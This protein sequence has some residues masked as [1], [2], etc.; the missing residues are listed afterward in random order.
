MSDLESCKKAC[1][2]IYP[3]CAAVNWWYT[4]SVCQFVADHEMDY[5][6]EEKS[7]VHYSIY[8]CYG[9]YAPGDSGYGY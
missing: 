1:L 6:S 8:F 7:F 4:Y 2:L 5:F 3:T 9:D